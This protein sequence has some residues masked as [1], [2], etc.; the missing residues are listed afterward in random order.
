VLLSCSPNSFHNNAAE[1]V[2]RAVC[3]EEGL[4]GN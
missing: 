3:G 2:M 1:K 4:V